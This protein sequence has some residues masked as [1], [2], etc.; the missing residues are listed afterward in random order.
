MGCVL[1]CMCVYVCVCVG[2]A[3]VTHKVNLSLP[4]RGQDL[5]ELSDLG[6]LAFASLKNGSHSSTH[7]PGER[8]RFSELSPV[9]CSAQ[10][11]LGTAN[12]ASLITSTFAGRCQRPERQRVGP[13]AAVPGQRGQGSLFGFIFSLCL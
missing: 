11:L 6:P 9:K 1:V 12:G 8:S 4:S 7:F 10:W 3:G 5:C 2:G 13:G